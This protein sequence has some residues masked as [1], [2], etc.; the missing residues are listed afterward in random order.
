MQR[1]AAK[2][3]ACFGSPPEKPRGFQSKIRDPGGGGEG[4]VSIQRLPEVGFQTREGA[5]PTAGKAVDLPVPLKREPFFFV[6]FPIPGSAANPTALCLDPCT[7]DGHMPLGLEWVY[8]G[9]PSS[10]RRSRRQCVK[11]GSCSRLFYTASQVK[12]SW[13]K[14]RRLVA[15]VRGRWHWGNVSAL[16]TMGIRVPRS[17]GEPAF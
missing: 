8:R 11:T 7:W 13:W 6:L 15:C 12:K 9:E 2:S 17:L 16:R 10:V 14:L 4:A 5:S 1:R 3:P